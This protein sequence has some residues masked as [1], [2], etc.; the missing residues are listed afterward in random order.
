VSAIRFLESISIDILSEDSFT[1]VEIKRSGV[2]GLISL[3]LE[4]AL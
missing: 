4:L 1:T 3:H 2:A